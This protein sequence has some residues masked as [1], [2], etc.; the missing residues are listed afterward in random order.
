M[1]LI[2]NGDGSVGPLSATEIG[3]LDGVT[4]SVQTQINSKP[5]GGTGAWT[6][7]TPALGGSGWAIGNGSTSGA[8]IQIGKTVYFRAVVLFGSTSSYSTTADPTV[9]LPVTCNTDSTSHAQMNLRMIRN[10]VGN[11]QGLILF[12]ATWIAL[13]YLGNGFTWSGIRSTTPATW[14][15]G[16]VWWMNGFYE[17]A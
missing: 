15:S 10:T 16:D 14:Q 12:N 5:T 3:Y 17:A 2:L 13:Y 7:Y 6:P 9:T 4:S 8:Y 1:P 11:Y